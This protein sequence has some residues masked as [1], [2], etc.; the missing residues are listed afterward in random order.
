[1]STKFDGHIRSVPPATLAAAERA[2]ETEPPAREAQSTSQEDQMSSGA[3]GALL[4]VPLIMAGPALLGAAAVVGV[5]V[6]VCYVAGKGLIAGAEAIHDRC[7]AHAARRRAWDGTRKN[8]YRRVQAAGPPERLEQRRQVYEAARQQQAAHIAHLTAT[9]SWLSAPVGEPEAFSLPPLDE[10]MRAM[11]P[12]SGELR[13]VDTLDRELIHDRLDARYRAARRALR[14]YEPG[15]LWEG[16]FAVSTVQLR[17]ASVDESL[18]Q[19]Q[20]TAAAERLRHA[21]RLVKMMES[22]AVERWEQRAAAL[23]ALQ[24]ANALLGQAGQLSTEYPQT[25]V[26]LEALHEQLVTAQEAYDRQAF[27][28]AAAQAHVVGQQ[29]QL[30]ASEPQQWEREALLAEIRALREEI[31]AHGPF[32]AADAQLNLLAAAEAR[33]AGSLPTAEALA[34]TA[35]MLDQ[36]NRWADDVLRRIETSAAGT[37]TRM[38]L[39]AHAAAELEAMGYMVEWSHALDAPPLPEE[40]WR[41]TGRRPAPTDPARTHTFVMDIEADGHVWFDATQG[42]RGKECDDILTFISGLQARGIEGYW[43]PFYSLEQTAGLFREML[44]REGYS[45]YEESTPEGL[46]YTLFRGQETYP[47]ALVHWDGRIESAVPH[48]GAM[49]GYIERV[50]A[51]IEQAQQRS[52]PQ[53]LRR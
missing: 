11:W 25:I 48:A 27:V 18:H 53:A 40:K 3:E 9:R 20:L 45:F 17:L 42:Y 36:A 32:P 5:G 28:E 12:E 6:G 41:L 39:A 44:D 49:E 1:M 21:E 43:E 30:L 37:I 46:V 16:L 50:R 31:V 38:H 13:I 8:V 35:A 29:F 24:E 7:Q 33:L 34:Q 4:V 15:G 2:E 19:G 47:G 51:E 22:E 23:N 52:S 26:Q 10:D 14:A